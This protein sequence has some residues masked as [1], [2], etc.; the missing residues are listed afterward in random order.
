MNVNEILSKLPENLLDELAID[1]HIN[2]YAKKIQGQTLF[3]LLIYCILTHKDNSLRSMASTYESVAFGLINGNANQGSIQFSSISDRISA[4]DY[5]YFE[6]IYKV[7]VEIYG[8]LIGQETST[9]TKFDSTIVTISSKLLK[10]GYHIKGNSEYY[11]QLKYTIGFTDIPTSVD[12]YT[13]QKYTS[14]NVALKESI[15][16]HAP[17]KTNG[18]TVFDRGI[19]ARKSFDSLTEQQV[20]FVSR[21]NVNCKHELIAEINLLENTTTSTLTITSDNWIYLFNQ[22]TQKTTYPLRCIKAIKTSNKEEIWF[23]TN[24]HDL[25]ADEITEIYKR[26]W[27]IEVFFKFLKQELRFSHLINRSENGAKV[28]LYATLIASILLLV[29]K[30]TNNLKGYKIM[31]LRFVQQLE[32]GVMRD[33]V[34]LTGGDPLIFDKMLKNT[35]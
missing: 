29:Y 17:L 2:R 6:R 25:Q 15:L 26:R 5:K 35:S 14:E 3:K 8:N 11:R 1:M 33:I 31:R 22:N 30:K 7:C 34:I 21:I 12:F 13:E 16:A 20:P 23:I 27:E 24:I 10:F 32:E 9:L 19:T 4:M 28:I 18:I